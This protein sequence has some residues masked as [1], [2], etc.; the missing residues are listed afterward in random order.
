MVS[1][2]RLISRK[3]EVKNRTGEKIGNRNN[4]NNKR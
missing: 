2:G 1:G 3:L 4:R